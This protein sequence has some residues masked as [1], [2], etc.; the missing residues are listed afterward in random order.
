MD[1]ILIMITI[2][3]FIIILF[4]AKHA[5][6]ELRADKDVNINLEN[7]EYAIVGI[8]FSL[9]VLIT[10]FNIVL[11]LTLRKTLDEW[12]AILI[13]LFGGN[14]VV[15]IVG[16]LPILTITEK[17]PVAV[18]KNLKFFIYLFMYI[19]I[20]FTFVYLMMK[21]VLYRPVNNKMTEDEFLDIIDKAEQEEGINEN[22]RELIKSV[23]DFDDLK[24]L[25]IYTP[26]IG[27][28]ALDKSVTKDDV[29]NAFKESGYSRLPIYDKSIDNI[30]GVIN[31]KDFYNKVLIEKKSLKSVIQPAVEVPEYME[32]KNLLSLLKINKSHMAIVKDEYGGTL[33]IVTMEDIL[34][35]LVGDIWDEHDKVTENIKKSND[36]KY[37]VNAACY[38]DDLSSIMDIEELED[39]DFSTVNGWVLSSLGKMGVKG[40]SFTYKDFLITVT[41]AS[42]KKILEISIEKVQNNNSDLE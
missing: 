28:I 4:A 12:L 30:I 16:V 21:K 7:N 31:H 5:I 18:I 23:L 35:E 8:N 40:D 11:V 2:L 19:T 34:E 15:L 29:T 13:S 32:V 36:G 9:I 42:N 1:N 38:I 10:L 24:V 26:R 39:E 25:D 14:A 6:S 17:A 3:L 37:L 41:K 22:E 20:P 33:G 27:I